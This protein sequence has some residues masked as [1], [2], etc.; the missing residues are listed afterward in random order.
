MVIHD[1][2]VYTNE[3]YVALEEELTK[4]VQ[5]FLTN[6]VQP[7]P[8]CVPLVQFELYIIT[9]F[10]L[11]LE[12]VHVVYLEKPERSPF[13]GQG[14]FLQHFVAMFDTQALSHVETHLESHVV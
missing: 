10:A 9:L 12:T 13:V 3:V 7:K 8:Y 4:L 1:G 11:L 6:V 2:K 14:P 5:L